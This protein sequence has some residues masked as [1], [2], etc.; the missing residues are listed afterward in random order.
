VFVHAKFFTDSLI[1]RSKPGVYPSGVSFSVSLKEGSMPYS[2]IWLPWR[3]LAVDKRPSLFRL[4]VGDEWKRFCSTGPQIWPHPD[5]N[6]CQGPS[7]WNGIT[8]YEAHSQK[9]SV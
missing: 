1:F 8:S 5:P 3:K 9:F 4:G 7:K 6:V 2:N